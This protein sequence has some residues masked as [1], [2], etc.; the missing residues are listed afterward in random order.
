MHIK[1]QIAVITGASSGIGEATAIALA[2]ADAHVVL[3][4]RNATK[5]QLLAEKIVS[6][7]GQASAYPVDLTNAQAVTQ[8]SNAIVQE[9]GIPDILI[10]NAGS[11]QWKHT[12]D[13]TPQEAI[14]M[15]AAPY[16]A[17]FN[18]THALLPHMLKQKW[19]FIINI[20]SASAYFA[21]PGATTYTTA[22][23]AMRGFNEALRADL[24]NT[25]IRVM[26]IAPGKVDTPY[27]KNNPNTENRIPT[28]ATLKPF[29]NTLTPNQVASAIVK[30]ILK[31]K[32]E[33][34]IPFSMK[35]TVW[36]A[37]IFPRPIE[38]L[39]IKTGPKRDRETPQP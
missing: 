19:G 15:M 33:V 34:I 30:G 29:Y 12:E 11:G 22:R 24:H 2:Q 14:D 37:R 25:G 32:R 6:S 3:L 5:L 20:T 7:G 35:L 4:A 28:V 27:F 8:I 31:N 21:M 1:N 18:I 16:F 36:V 26:L 23:W 38:W 17:A 10:N 39:I 9:I 13:T